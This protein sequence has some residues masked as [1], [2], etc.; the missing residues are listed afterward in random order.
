MADI[1]TT[2]KRELVTI[3]ADPWTAEGAVHPGLAAFMRVM[4]SRDLRVAHRA[5]RG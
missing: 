2:V 5:G 1:E 3:L 4:Q